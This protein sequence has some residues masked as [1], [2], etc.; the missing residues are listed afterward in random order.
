MQATATNSNDLHFV[1]TNASQLGARSADAVA[2]VSPSDLAIG[3]RDLCKRYDGPLA[4][5]G[6]SFD[7]AQGESTLR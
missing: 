6:V 5:D 2:S 4:V 1:T 3:V 7:V